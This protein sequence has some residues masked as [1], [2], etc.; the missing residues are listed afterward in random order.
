MP[1][2][3]PNMA[4]KAG[5]LGSGTMGIMII[6][7][8]VKMPAQPKPATARPKMS[9][10][11]DGAAAQMMEPSSKTAMQVRNVLHFVVCQMSCARLPKFRRGSAYH[12]A[13]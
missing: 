13:S 8:P 6:I 7:P 10:A 3:T 1:K 12:L 11:D 9:A 2:T 4:W 5:R